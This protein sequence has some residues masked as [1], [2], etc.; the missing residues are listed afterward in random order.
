MKFSKEKFIAGYK[1][2]Y[3]DESHDFIVALGNLLEKT[4]NDGFQDGMKQC[5]RLAEVV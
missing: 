2:Q 1:K 3:G 5:G 4:Y